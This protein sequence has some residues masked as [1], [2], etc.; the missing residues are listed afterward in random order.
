MR[1]Y[2]RR[3]KKKIDKENYDP[4]NGADS[5][6]NRMTAIPPASKPKSKDLED[7]ELP[8]ME[9]GSQQ[10]DILKLSDIYYDILSGKRDKKK[11]TKEK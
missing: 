5:M 8:Q 3:K 6:F 11:L 7:E 10:P 1:K 9:R 4:V 2:N